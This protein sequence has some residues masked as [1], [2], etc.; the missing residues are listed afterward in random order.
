MKDKTSDT[1]IYQENEGNNCSNEKRAPDFANSVLEGVQTAL[2]VCVAAVGSPMAFEV[3]FS[4]EAAAFEFLLE[5]INFVQSFAIFDVV[6]KLFLHFTSKLKQI[7]FVKIII[8]CIA[9]I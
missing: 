9:D 2:C 7:Y 5:A 8:T 6:L 1:V 3:S 4:I